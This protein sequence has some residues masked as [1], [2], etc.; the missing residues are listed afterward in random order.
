[1]IDLSING[2]SYSILV[3]EST[4]LL[5]VL[6]DHLHLSGTKFGCGVAQCGACTVHMN[7]K[8]IRSCV[9]PVS[10]AKG[11]AVTTIEGIGSSDELH[12]VQKAWLEQSVPQCG[13]CQP[14][15]IMQAV[16]F[17]NENQNPT[18]K[19]IE[20][21]MSGNICRCGTY[22]RIVKAIKS[23]NGES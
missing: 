4:P 17:L 2:K 11:S 16:A 13:Y 22:P 14:G 18:D 12:P 10:A 6:R 1:M 20:Q 15:Q 8:A 7:G 19:D 9:T 5:W 21:A 23:V 3:D